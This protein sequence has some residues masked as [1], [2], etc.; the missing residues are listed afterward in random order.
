MNSNSFILKKLIFNPIFLVGL[1]LR[2][3]LIL[4]VTPVAVMEWYVPFLAYTSTIF[5]IDP[6][7]SWV[8]SG[9]NI[10]AFPYGY[11]MWVVFL[12]VTFISKYTGLPLQYGYEFMILI[13]D[14]C[15]LFTLN[16]ILPERQRLL[17]IAYWLSPII[18]FACYGL[19]YN[20]VIPAL[21][22]TLSIM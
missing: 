13:A 11:V 9:G 3:T 14:F 7:S 20:D 18:I 4:Y 2:L 5:T 10:G 22:L 17:L 15:L 19:G 6:W 21:L 12:P 8:S 16:K 1:V